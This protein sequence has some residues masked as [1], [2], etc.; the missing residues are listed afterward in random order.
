MLHVSTLELTERFN[1]IAARYVFRLANELIKACRHCKLG[2]ICYYLVDICY[3][4]M[5]DQT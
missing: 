2:N 5:I 4:I 3:C 1:C